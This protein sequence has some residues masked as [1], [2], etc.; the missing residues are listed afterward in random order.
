[1]VH[2]MIPEVLQAD[3]TQPEWQEKHYSILYASRYITISANTAKDLVKFYAHI[4]QDKIDVVYN[5]VSQEFSRYPY[6][7]GYLK[8]LPNKRSTVDVFV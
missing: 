6:L 5:G 1:M 3:L 7:F 8:I 4:T 2:D